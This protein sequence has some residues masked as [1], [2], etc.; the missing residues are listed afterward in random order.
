M[1][2]KNRM[3]K[4]RLNNVWRG[5]YQFLTHILNSHVPVNIP[6]VSIEKE[7]TGLFPL[8]TQFITT[9]G[10]KLAAQELLKRSSI[11]VYVG[12]ENNRYSPMLAR[13]A[14]FVDQCND[15]E[16]NTVSYSSFFMQESI[17]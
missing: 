1:N 17:V 9:A 15:L 12:T 2:V 6:L 5:L 3:S 13:Q 16:L 14:G 4:C 7:D 11:I 10:G 8:V